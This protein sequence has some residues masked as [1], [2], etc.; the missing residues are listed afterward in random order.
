M[1]SPEN[2]SRHQQRNGSKERP[3]ERHRRTPDQRGEAGGH[4]QCQTPDDADWL[5]PAATPE[6]GQHDQQAQQPALE[7]GDGLD[8]LANRARTGVLAKPSGECLPGEPD[9]EQH[10]ANQQTTPNDRPVTQ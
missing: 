4:R 6:A 7:L 5:S 8:F 9:E 1:Q 2:G 3:D 10:S